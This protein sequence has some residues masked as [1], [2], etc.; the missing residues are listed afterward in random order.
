[1]CV[2]STV[3]ACMYVHTFVYVHKYMHVCTVCEKEGLSELESV[4]YRLA[5]PDHP[6]ILTSGSAR[7]YVLV[8]IYCICICT[9]CI[10]TYSSVYLYIK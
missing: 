9:F 2:Y 5:E 1:M 3:C 8:C 4:R 6:S 7:L 10:C